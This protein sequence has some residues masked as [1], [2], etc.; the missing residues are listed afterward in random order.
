MPVFRLLIAFVLHIAF[1]SDVLAQ[2]QYHTWYFGYGAGLDFKPLVPTRLLDGKTATDEG[3]A[4]YSDPATGELLFYTD[5]R[6]VWNR[7]HEEMPGGFGLYGHESSTQSA[8]IIPDPASPNKFFIFTTDHSGYAEDPPRGLHYSIVDMSLDG[9]L[10]EVVAKNVRLHSSTTEKLTAVRICEGA[11]YWILAHEMNSNVFLAYYLDEKGLRTPVRSAVGRVQGRTALEGIGYMALSPDASMLAVAVFEDSLDESFAEVFKFDA[12]T[13]L[14]YDAIELPPLTQ[15]YGVCFSPDNSR[16]YISAQTFI[17]QFTLSTWDRSRIWASRRSFQNTEQC[18]ALRLGPDGRIYVANDLW[19]GI[20]RAPNEQGTSADFQPSAIS[21][22]PGSSIFSLPNNIEANVNL[23]FC[24]TPIAR[25]RDFTDT[26]CVGG[27]VDFYDSSRFSPTAWTWELEGATPPISSDRDP[28]LICYPNPGKFEVR[29]IAS[30]SSGIDTAIA[31]IVVIP[32]PLPEAAFTAQD[33]IC[34][35]ECITLANTSERATSFDWKFEDG[36]PASSTAEHPGQ[37]CFATEGVKKIELVAGNSEG[38]DTAV[39]YVYVIDCKPPLASFDHDKLICVGECIDLND[40]SIDATAWQWTFTGASVA[41]SVLQEPTLICYSTVGSFEIKLVAR[42]SVG[43]DSMTSTV[44]VVECH[45]P[46]AVLPDTTVCEKTCI[47]FSDMS[48]GS[49]TEW[50]WLFDGGNPGF[51]TVE[52]PG[53]VCYSN[54]GIY[55]VKLVIANEHGKDSLIRFVTVTE[56]QTE[57]ISNLVFSDSISSCDIID[58]AIWVRA[59]CAGSPVGLLTQPSGFTGSFTGQQLAA[60]EQLRIPLTFRPDGLGIKQGSLELMID[61]VPRS[62]PYEFNVASWVGEL[63]IDPASVQLRA[64]DACEVFETVVTIRMTGCD[65]IELA[66]IV[67]DN[68]QGN[69]KFSVEPGAVPVA[70]VGGDAHDVR[71]TYDPSGAG[72]DVCDLILIS[73]TGEEWRIPVTADPGVVKSAR[74]ALEASS[75]SGSIDLDKPKSVELVMLDAIEQAVDLLQVDVELAYNSDV[76]SIADI[77]STSGWTAVRTENAT[78]AVIRLT[79][80]AAQDQPAGST[81]A[82]IVFRGFLAREESTDVRL[83]NVRFNTDQPEYAACVLTPLPFGEATATISAYCGDDLMRNMLS[84]RP[85]LGML[86]RPNPLLSATDAVVLIRSGIATDYKLQVLDL[87]G[88]LV[89]EK[90]GRLEPGHNEVPVSTG[91]LTSGSYTVT[92]SAGSQ[93]LSRSIIVE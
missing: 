26:I 37:V 72:A 56:G 48:Q 33:T 52:D 7:L 13:G 81:L 19:L 41:G 70:M 92:L 5:G 15:A 36:T 93:T 57:V 47:E 20:I 69:T 11:A 24:S 91:Q 51:S 58:T 71:I 44:R 14:V 9:G 75:L 42:N 39:R 86:V 28:K 22:L 31:T 55:S 43:V 3:G 88:I 85:I 30:N 25:M 76:I 32:C 12:T 66:N 65:Y 89:R 18:S 60:G 59:G 8:L 45:A 35:T 83:S 79:R 38:L 61:G 73:A 68:S 46:K 67:F 77:I 16:L 49:P 64:S 90:S 50:L 54:P 84:D 34:L 40:L 63:H 82:T 53:A 10:G 74:I 27:C 87:R 4:S 21:I 6:S 17:E 80:T 2:K 62:I 1:A 23:P 29:M 78:G